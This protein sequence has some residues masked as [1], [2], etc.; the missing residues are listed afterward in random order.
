MHV[1]EK[2]PLVANK[3]KKD[4]IEVFGEDKQM[5]KFKAARSVKKYCSC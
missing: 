2:E 4:T 5:F 3:R 1:Q